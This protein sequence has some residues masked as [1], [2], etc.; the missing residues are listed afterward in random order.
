MKTSW[1]VIAGICAFLSAF[2]TFIIISTLRNAPMA[3]PL[4]FEQHAGQLGPGGPQSKTPISVIEALDPRKANPPPADHSTPPTPT[5]DGSGLDTHKTEIGQENRDR[6]IFLDVTQGDTERNEA[7]NRLLAAKNTILQQDLLTILARSDERSR[8][9]AFA[10]QFLGVLASDES[11]PDDAHQIAL[12][13]LKSL[14][15]DRDRPVRREALQA[16]V[17]N[18]DPIAMGMLSTAL[19]DA[20]WSADR[21]LI[22]RCL[23]E[24]NAVAKM[25]EIR[26]FLHDPDPVVEIAALYVLGEWKDVVSQADFATASRSKNIRIQR[27]GSLALQKVSGAMGGP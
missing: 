7:M 22:I 8:F 25:S 27:A 19:T 3:D 14:L 2:G 24:S 23:F 11:L 13:A 26:T 21:D 5:I 16:L 9:R 6:T 20:A 18:A 10:A 17:R 12:D 15:T 4:P 1:A